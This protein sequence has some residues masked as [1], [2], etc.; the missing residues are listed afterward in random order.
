MNG[1]FK[2]KH[3]VKHNINIEELTA[4]Y[5]TIIP[6]KMYSYILRRSNDIWKCSFT[7]STSD[8]Y[9]LINKDTAFRNIISN[10]TQRDIIFE[11]PPLE[12]MIE[13]YTPY[14]RS[15]AYKQSQHWSQLEYEDLVQMCFLSM[16][17]LYRKGY[18][19][20]KHLLE[21]TYIRD[22]LLSIRK[23]RTDKDI[24]S[25]DSKYGKD[26]SLTISDT[27]EDVAFTNKRDD[28]EYLAEILYIFNEVKEMII[29]QIG[30]RRFEQLFNE[31]KNKTTSTNGQQTM[32]RLRR[33]FAQ[34]NITL[35]S[36]RK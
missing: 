15:L 25:I 3:N 17:K 20:N 6:E 32:F 7:V 31:Y 12:I 14:V 9:N 21:T 5:N 29:E 16:I 11:Q 27:L 30:E 34:N 23:N 33:S 24:V 8:K 13:L 35:N 18:F 2:I 28:D 1:L 19:L 26:E 10:I 4:V 22:V 36:F